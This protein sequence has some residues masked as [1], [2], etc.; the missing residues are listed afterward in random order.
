MTRYEIQIQEGPPHGGLYELE[1]TTYFHVV[2]VDTQAVVLTFRGEMEASLS[3]DTG[4]WDDYRFSGVRDLTLAP[5]Q[6]SVLVRYYDGHEE[7]VLLPG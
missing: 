1:Q 3:P 7:T 5:E 6:R 4:L 2:D